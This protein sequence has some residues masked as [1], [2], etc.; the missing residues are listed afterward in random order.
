MKLSIATAA[1]LG[2]LSL[3]VAAPPA[4]A[5]GS[6]T[7]VRVALLDM[8][9]L[10]GRGPAGGWGMM[11]PGSGP[12]TGG[13]GRFGPGFGM[14]AHGGYGPGY[15]MMGQGPGGY[16]QG[17][18]MMGMGRMAVRADHSSVKAGEVHFT[19]TNW[20][21]GIVHEM[22]VV[23]VDN[24]D[25]PLPYDYNTGRVAEDQVKSL[26]EVGDLRPNATGTLDVNLAPGS[27]LLICNVPGHYAAGM[28]TDLTVTP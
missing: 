1:A 7:E 9:A 27:Y 21:Q 24:P 26:G 22:I 2:L 12:A 19:V 25:A 8:S 16:G 14:M 20:S 15:G 11:G 13:P 17:W 4:F 18:G 28:V 6:G 5:A 3:G 10:M 23:A